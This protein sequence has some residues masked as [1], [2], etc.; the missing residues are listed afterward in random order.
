MTGYGEVVGPLPRPVGP[1]S[2]GGR[3]GLGREILQVG[4][5]GRPF[6]ECVRVVA[7]GLVVVAVR[8]LVSVGATCDTGDGEVVGLLVRPVGPRSGGG[9]RGLGRD[10]LQVGGGGRPSSE[11]VR[12]VATGI[13]VVAV[14]GL[15]LEALS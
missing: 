3:R 11:C 14:A 4:R 10:I 1:R 7:T 12:A 13:V 9:R 8:G 5:G 2:G 6:S 15:S